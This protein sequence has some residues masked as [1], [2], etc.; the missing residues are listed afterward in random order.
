MCVNNIC[1][2]G[3][4]YNKML[5]VIYLVMC[6]STMQDAAKGRYYVRVLGLHATHINEDE[7]EYSNYVR[8]L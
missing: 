3:Y 4:L 2:R 6:T 1:I 7:F 5:S 8:N